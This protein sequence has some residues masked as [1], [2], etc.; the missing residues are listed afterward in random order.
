MQRDHSDD[1]RRK[2]LRHTNGPGRFVCESKSKGK[3]IGFSFIHTT[4]Y[5][6]LL[7]LRNPVG[8][9]L[10]E[11][12]TISFVQ[13]RFYQ[14]GG[15]YECSEHRLDNVEQGL[16]R[17]KKAV[18]NSDVTN[19]IVTS[20]DPGIG[21]VVAKLKVTGAPQGFEKW[22]LP[23]YL[24]GPSQLFI[25]A[26]APNVEVGAHS[27][28]A[29]DG[30]RFMVSGSILFDGKELTAGDWMFIPKGKKYAFRVGATGACMCYCYCCSCVP[31]LQ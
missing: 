28:D 21:D 30:I 17:I 22:Q 6:D 18:G 25:S 26:A 20:R 3:V 1:S 15:N 11:S 4:G 27:H 31:R 8:S 10:S 23:V 14:E 29:G 13:H 2:H 19:N 7:V 9:P 12:T 5:K 24:N 16:D